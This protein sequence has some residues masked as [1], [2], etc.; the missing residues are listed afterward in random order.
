M[1]IYDTYDIYWEKFSKGDYNPWKQ[2][3]ENK[4]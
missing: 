1:D 4:N 2:T 3:K